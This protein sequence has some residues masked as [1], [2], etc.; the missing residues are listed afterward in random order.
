MVRCMVRTLYV[1]VHT[2][3]IYH[4][5]S[6]ITYTCPLPHTVNVVETDHHFLL[7]GTCGPDL[8]VVST[9]LATTPGQYF[10]RT[11][12]HTHP[13]KVCL[14]PIQIVITCL[15]SNSSPH[16]HTV[17]NLLRT[18]CMLIEYTALL[19]YRVIE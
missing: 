7:S 1:H 12:M 3:H 16:M 5:Q 4:T 15:Y 10:Q 13:T 6:T 14:P 11:H 2:S 18:T 17:C 8:R 9:C 19:Y